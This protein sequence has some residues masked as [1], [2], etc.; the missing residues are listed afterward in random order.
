MTP[1]HDLESEVLPPG[2]GLHLRLLQGLPPSVTSVVPP[3][4]ITLHLLSTG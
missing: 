2:D 3:R 1:R 4:A